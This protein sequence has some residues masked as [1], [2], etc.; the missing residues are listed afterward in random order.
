MTD[1]LKGNSFA[2]IN[3]IT[4]N[5]QV[6]HHRYQLIINYSFHY[7]FFKGFFNALIQLI[8]VFLFSSSFFVNKISFGSIFINFIFTLLIV[9]YLFI[10]YFRIATISLKFCAICLIYMVRIFFFIFIGIFLRSDCLAFLMMPYFIKKGHFLWLS[11]IERYLL[12]ELI[13]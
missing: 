9:I 13:L 3:F 12:I 11:Y 1:S 4:L 7:F 10:F 8:L 5:A 2:L 6:I